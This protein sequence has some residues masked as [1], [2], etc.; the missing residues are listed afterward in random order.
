M[1]ATKKNSE[2]S[3]GTVGFVPLARLV[4]VSVP[5]FPKQTIPEVRDE[6]FRTGNLSDW[7]RF[8]LD[9]GIPG[10]FPS[11]NQCRKALKHV[12]V[13]IVDFLQATKV[14]YPP[15]RFSSQHLSL[16]LSSM[17]MQLV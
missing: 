16:Y 6:Y 2:E 14:G 12:W 17:R 1:V 7:Q 8:M 10:H 4:S 11:K 3:G 15:H 9:L 13:N 5:R